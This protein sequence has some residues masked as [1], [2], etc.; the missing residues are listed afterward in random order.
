M[1]APLTAL[2]LL[3]AGHAL[4][5]QSGPTFIRLGVNEGLSQN[6]VR[7]IFQDRQGFIWI[8]TGDGLNRYDGVQIRKYRQSIRDHSA[9]R[10]P[11]KLLNGKIHQ[12]EAGYLWMIVDGQ[13]VRMDPVT[14][15]FTVLKQLGRDLEH[16]IIGLQGRFLYTCNMSTVEIIDTV[17]KQS[18]KLSLPDAFASY[19]PS[20]GQLQVL[21]RKGNALHAYDPATQAHRQLFHSGRDS[22]YAATRSGHSLLISAGHQL[23]DYS[24]PLGRI[25]ARY[26]QT[27]EQRYPIFAPVVKTPRG[28]VLLSIPSQG[29]VRIDSLT[30]RWQNYTN[31]ALD[32]YSLSSNLVHTA[33]VD[34]AGNSWFG[35]E[36]GGINRL[37][38]QPRLFHGYPDLATTRRES[39]LLMV[40]S[41]Y[42]AAGS[43]Y[44]G[45]YALGLYIVDTG[46]GRARQVFTPTNHHDPTFR[47]IF[48]IKA[49]GK[50]R[51]WM[52]HG[53]KVGI[54]DLDKGQFNQYTT[55]GYV[56]KGRHHNIVQ[57]FAQAGANRY[58]VGTVQSTYLLQD[59]G[60][61]FVVTD[62]GLQL[63][64]LEGDIQCLYRKDNGD[65]LVGKGE[66]KG[67]YVLRLRDQQ[68]PQLVDSG[69][70]G[71]TIKQLYRDRY[72]QAN[73]YATNAGIVI[74]QDGSATHTL[75]DEENG[76]SND[77]IYSI[78]P[79]H[80]HSFWVSTNKGINRISLQPGDSL[81][82][83]TIQQFGI[84]HGLQSNE[85]NTG[86]YYQSGHDLFFGGVTGINWFDCQHFTQKH[87]APRAYV[88]DLL[89]NEKPF[90]TD[91]AAN[92]LRHIRL[93]HRENNLVLRFA[94]LD[95]A[96]PALHQYRYRLVGYDKDWVRAPAIPE[97]RYNR[98]PAGHY[99]F[100]IMVANNE[101]VWSAPVPLLTLAITPP[102]WQTW[103]FRVAVA[104]VVLAA[105]FGFFRYLL[106]RKM[107]KQRRLL[108]QQL[109]V[110]HE[111]M[112]ISRDMHDELGTGLSKIALLSEVAKTQPIAGHEH[113]IIHEINDTSRNLSDKMGEII[114]ALNPHNDTLGN[115]AAY[116]KEYVYET[117]DAL[118]VRVTVD[119][120]DNIP[121][122]SLR[123]LVRR[124][125]LLV[126]KEALNNA[127]KHAGA[128]TL[129]FSLVIHADS[130]LFTVQ[131]DGAGFANRPV[132]QAANGKRNG[133]ANM[134]A[135]MESIDGFLEIVSTTGTGT[136]IRYGIPL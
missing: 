9:R 64:S 79:E 72:R 83:A 39:S 105:I 96:D 108:E 135:R 82:V 5:G 36:G 97:A 119:F 42:A 115:L 75:I 48:F 52:N 109:A 66:G 80:D 65:L 69:L 37:S 22:L 43:I 85:F 31:D 86:A 70:Q 60:Q 91:T 30:G 62:L 53:N 34:N 23:L 16:A 51:T 127:L 94:A 88:T 49:D 32:P 101:G 58:L 90:H 71:L 55:I 103:W 15:T 89:V 84:Q 74:Q 26:P 81:R 21:Y 110:N 2:L 117:T 78:L 130:I 24:L 99:Q 10:F 111:R 11:G 41:L 27:G 92:F 20:P 61:H 116:L 77:Y 87:F 122:I 106:R 104:L 56:R 50:G 47:G 28:D 136:A 29:I 8:G 1:K 131:D 134:Q 100:E 7:E 98:L 73:W 46:T 124:Q 38:A 67:Y 13:L 17:S 59:V 95:F 76:L 125:L 129:R 54:A 63:P 25:T 4:L 118:P 107:E 114:W 3:L 113:K 121:E 133:L 123:H 14:E 126:T 19:A 18:T 35:T 40:K 132:Q 44:I 33:F 12:D 120:P 102:Y 112:R 45:T 68:P 57:C 128:A 93:H 6:S